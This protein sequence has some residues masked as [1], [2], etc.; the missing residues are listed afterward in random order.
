MSDPNT[1]SVITGFVVMLR[2]ETDFENMKKNFDS[3]RLTRLQEWSPRSLIT[4]ELLDKTRSI[5]GKGYVN[6]I[7]H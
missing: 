5:R 2:G 4:D 6:D 7:S 3:I 1:I